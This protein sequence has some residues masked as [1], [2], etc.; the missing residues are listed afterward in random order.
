MG[1]ENIAD[2]LWTAYFFC[3]DLEYCLSFKSQTQI[4][5]LIY[6]IPGWHFNMVS[7]LGCDLKLWYYRLIF[8]IVVAL[9][10]TSRFIKLCKSVI[11]ESAYFLVVNCWNELMKYD[12]RDL[13]VIHLFIGATN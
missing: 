13:I 1:N 5:I 3:Y 6:L 9:I 2:I 8:Y 10:C 7:F 12:V 11:W 4:S